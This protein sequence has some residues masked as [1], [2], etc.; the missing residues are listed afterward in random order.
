MARSHIVAP[1]RAES[2]P[3]AWS[4]RLPILGIATFGLVAAIA[5]AAYQ[6]KMVA[7]IWDPFFGDASSE[8]VVT[9]AVIAFLPIPDAL[10]GVVG[11]GA[12]MLAEA[13]GG[14]E[15][16]RDMPWIVL[17]FGALISV[18]A[19]V[20]A[21]LILTQALVVH[22]WCSLCLASAIISLVIFALGVH[23]PLASLRY[24][25]QIRRR[26]ESVWEALW[27]W[28]ADQGRL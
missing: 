2:S 14:E 21:G 13:I 8:H 4:E 25:S 6:L 26:H 24:L 22:A 3:S 11:Y 5:L 12:E 17:A 28:R 10:L 15:R 7:N 16:W 19:L 9:S 23:E 18:M 20:G 1:A 27:G